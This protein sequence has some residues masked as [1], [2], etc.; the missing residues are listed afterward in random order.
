MGED[1]NLEGVKIG[2]RRKTGLPL[3]KRKFR[4]EA[5]LG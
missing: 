5:K 1:R 3:L 4:F 2:V